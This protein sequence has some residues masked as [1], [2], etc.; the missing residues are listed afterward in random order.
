MGISLEDPHLTLDVGNEFFGVNGGVCDVAELTG[1]LLEFPE[2]R[3]CLDK[4]GVL[5]W[6]CLGGL[7]STHPT[8][9][10][11]DSCINNES[12]CDTYKLCLCDWIASRRRIV[13]TLVEPL[14]KDL[15]GL[16]RLVRRAEAVFVCLHICSRYVGI[17]LVGMFDQLQ[18][19]LGIIPHV[20]VFKQQ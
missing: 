12:L 10:L 4:L 6:T 3:L 16:S 1:H 20:R 13:Q 19:C 17:V 8:I 15:E 18:S 9:F 11:V 14:N 5:G 7:V 2:V